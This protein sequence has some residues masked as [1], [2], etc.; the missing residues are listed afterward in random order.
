KFRAALH[1][2]TVETFGIAAGQAEGQPGVRSRRKGEEG[3]K[4]PAAWS[5]PGKDPGMYS[6]HSLCR[7]RFR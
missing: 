6:A 7:R 4:I 1:L 3:K 5:R 2:I